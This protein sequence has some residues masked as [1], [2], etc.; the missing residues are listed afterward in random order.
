MTDTF[1]SSGRS[2]RQ[3][4]LSDIPGFNHSRRSWTTNGM[5]VT[6][7]TATYAHPGFSFRSGGDGFNAFSNFLQPSRTR[8]S[9]GGGLLGGGLLGGAINMLNGLS[10]S[11]MRREK[12]GRRIE[13]D[14]YVSESDDSTSDSAG[15]EDDLA[16]GSLPRTRA[17]HSQTV[18]GRLKD[19]IIDHGRQHT[20]MAS[21]EFVYEQPSPEAPSRN[22]TR[23]D[24][25][26]F[27]SKSPEP[28]RSSRQ[29]RARTTNYDRTPESSPERP[30]DIPV[31]TQNA[32]T[33]RL[34]REVASLQ[35]AV[36]SERKQYLLAK[37]L[38]QQASQRSSIDANY[39]QDLL[40][41]VKL[42]GTL[43]ASAQRKLQVA[44][45]QQ[46]HEATTRRTQ[47][48]PRRQPSPRRR[49][50]YESEYDDDDEAFDPWHNF[51]STSRSNIPFQDPLR[52]TGAFDPL[53]G[54]RVF[55]HLFAEM[56]GAHSN[57]NGFHFYAGP[58]GPSFQRTTS[59]ANG[60]AP[61]AT[62]RPR[63]SSDT[64][65]PQSRRDP[66]PAPRIPS[67]PLRA[68]EVSRLFEKYNSSWNALSATFPT[69]PYPTRTLL[70]PALCDPSTI[71]HALS[72]TW[73]TE[74]IMQAN[75]ALFLLLALDFTPVI[76]DT[77]LV[78]FDNLSVTDAQVKTLVSVLKKE[79]MRWHSDRLGRRNEDVPGGGRNEKLQ[80]DER[81][82]AVFHGVCGLMEFALGRAD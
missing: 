26:R 57:A 79:K 43:L 11:Q 39:I 48:Q 80:K 34:D 6:M 16:Y 52:H 62:N 56:D 70:A 58:G 25:R 51:S 74:Q 73:S 22:D 32:R 78:T 67:N 19:R 71:P 33:T 38:F 37:S 55:D 76:S 21:E 28:P 41:Q 59:H 50:H 72:R 45:E 13:R 68:K 24:R 42:H 64:N 81:A 36:E 12:P 60:R 7:E 5:N 18:F 63:D 20:N 14:A 15:S 69:I 49:S 10:N 8:P 17:A 82:R 53:G 35:H 30:A 1:Y 66:Q 54:F 3:R 31:H 75:T 47:P 40:N 4:D 23:S 29:Q 77:G 2:R 44:K 27:R 46:R 61:R 9:R 65:V